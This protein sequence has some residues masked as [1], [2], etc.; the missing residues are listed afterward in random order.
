M[1]PF[2]DH[3]CRQALVDPGLAGVELGAAAVGL[4]LML[5]RLPGLLTLSDEGLFPLLG[6]V[7]CC[8][9]RFGVQIV[10]LV[11]V[12]FGQSGGRMCVDLQVILVED[13]LPCFFLGVV[14]ASCPLPSR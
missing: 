11:F 4:P 14:D 5:A 2:F 9:A 10:L 3:G 12:D 7:G 8:S 13:A 6:L 1:E